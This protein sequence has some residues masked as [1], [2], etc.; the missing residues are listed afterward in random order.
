MFPLWA[1]FVILMIFPAGPKKRVTEIIFYKYYIII[2][3][4]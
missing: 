3:Y 1:E 4:G 2:F